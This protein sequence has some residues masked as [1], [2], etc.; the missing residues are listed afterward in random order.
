MRVSMRRRPANLNSKLKRG[1]STWVPT[2]EST[3]DESENLC[4][5]IVKVIP[6]VSGGKGNH[7]TP[8]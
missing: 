4:S 2:S 6:A 5:D 1:K 7:G 8:K 3:T